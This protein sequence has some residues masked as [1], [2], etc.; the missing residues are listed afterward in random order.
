MINT[1]LKLKPFR[2]SLALSGSA[3]GLYL[4]TLIYPTLQRPAYNGF[5]ILLPR[6]Q[7]IAYEAFILLFFQLAVY[8][9]LKDKRTTWYPLLAYPK[10]MRKTFI[11]K[12]LTALIAT[13][14]I[15]IF[16]SF[17]HCM[18]VTSQD[19][20]YLWMLYAIHFTF[21]LLENY[22]IADGYLDTR[23]VN[24]IHVLTLPFF[25]FAIVNQHDWLPILV[26]LRLPITILLVM[27]YAV[28]FI[29]IDTNCRRILFHEIFLRD[30]FK[31]NANGPIVLVNAKIV[32]CGKYLNLYHRLNP[33]HNGY[34][35]FIAYFDILLKKN[36]T[37]LLV[38][39]AFFLL[40]F[41]WLFL[42]VLLFLILRLFIDA[43]K[44][45]KLKYRVQ[46]S[47]K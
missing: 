36:K 37:L 4:L 43:F 11:K 15:I 27:I 45:K 42:C 17:L 23:I 22:G 14:P 5:N 10:S 21:F 46:G 28:L 24:I 38:M 8:H 29:F 41:Y 16:A 30:Y 32:K 18:T 34:W 40:K 35:R 20:T 9:L 26:N 44:L 47:I 39:L 7:F 25:Y 6:E 33:N 31:N 13:L 3:A 2:Y 19:L 12:S 1:M